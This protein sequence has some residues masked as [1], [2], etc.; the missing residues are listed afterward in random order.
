MQGSVT[1]RY[2]V[3]QLNVDVDITLKGKCRERE[4][5]NNCGISEQNTCVKNHLKSKCILLRLVRL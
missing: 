3:C 1:A 4:G 2:Y 5:C